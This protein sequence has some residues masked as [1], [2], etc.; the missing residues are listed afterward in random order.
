MR[1]SKLLKAGGAGFLLSL[2]LA[3][4]ALPAS[5]DNAVTE[6]ALEIRISDHRQAIGDFERLDVTIER[7]G[8]HPASSERAAG[9]LD[10]APDTAVIDLTQVV[11][12][13]AIT[14][15]MASLPPDAYDAVR[16]VVAGG[17]GELK[18]NGNIV[19]VPGFEESARAIFTLQA[20]EVATLFMDV[21]VES[22]EDHP[23]GGYQMHL[24]EVRVN[25]ITYKLRVLLSCQGQFSLD[26]G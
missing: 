22:E 6:G 5:S 4:Q 25:P 23:G 18:A 12:D 21:I 2:L 7:V 16:L 26:F 1:I 19:E 17:E 15:L 24:L 11:G 14:I 13:Q 10:F 8:V 3:C 20:G 9:W